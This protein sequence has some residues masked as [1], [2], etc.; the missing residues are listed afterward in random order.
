[1]P[2]DMSNASCPACGQMGTLAIRPDDFTI[3]CIACMER[4]DVDSDEGRD[5]LSM[6]SYGYDADQAS[7]RLNDFVRST[8]R[9]NRVVLFAFEFTT[10]AA[11][12]AGVFAAH[13]IDAHRRYRDE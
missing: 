2:V 1:M 10:A 11:K 4:W 13:M 5:I 7:K 6:G 9:V 12:A 8:T 3:G